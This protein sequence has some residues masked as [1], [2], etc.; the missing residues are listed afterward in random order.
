MI[1]GRSRAHDYFRAFEEGMG[2]EEVAE[3]LQV[4]VGTVERYRQLPRFY[5]LAELEDIAIKLRQRRSHLST[6]YKIAR[7]DPRFHPF[8]NMFLLAA[9]CRR[10]LKAGRILSR[11]EVNA[12]LKKAY[13][14]EVHGEAY[15]MVF[16]EA[17]LANP[18]R[19][20]IAAL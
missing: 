17:N 16:S 18:R 15:K 9:I 6:I 19:R 3:K 7:R 11:L 20:P 8:D 13:D 14:P 1:R 10:I 12:A 2:D 4:S 5:D